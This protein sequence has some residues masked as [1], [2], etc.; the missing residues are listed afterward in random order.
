M[1]YNTHLPHF[2]I[3]NTIL[4]DLPNPSEVLKRRLLWEGLLY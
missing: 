3:H 1:K 4:Y 2:S